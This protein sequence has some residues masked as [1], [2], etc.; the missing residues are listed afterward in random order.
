MWGFVNSS[1]LPFQE[2]EIWPEADGMKISTLCLTEE[3]LFV[4]TQRDKNYKEEKLKIPIDQNRN[5]LSEDSKEEYEENFRLSPEAI[6]RELKIQ[7]V[8]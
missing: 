8:V 2:V 1:S 4:T 7:H 6:K 5:I 3:N